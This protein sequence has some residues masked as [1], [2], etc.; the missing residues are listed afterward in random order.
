MRRTTTIPTVSRRR[1][2]APAVA[3]ALLAA[4][5]AAPSFAGRVQAQT[6]PAAKPQSYTD[7][8]RA[9]QKAR[10]E[11]LKADNGWLTVAG[12]FWL[13]EGD[14]TFG[15]APGNTIVLP[16]HSAADLAGV[17]TH[18]GGTTTVRANPGVVLRIGA[19]TVTSRALRS[20]AEGA[21]DVVEMGRLRFFVIHRG[22]RDAIRMRDLES[23]GRT[24][25]N[26]IRT[27]GIDPK[28]RI[29]ARFEP[30]DPPHR[31]PIA[32]IIGTVDSMVC[33][34][35]LVFMAGGREVRL[36]PVLEEPDATELFLIFSDLTSGDETY[37]AGR[38]LYA[39]LPQ[40]GK[41]IVDFNKAYNPPC[42]FTEFATCPLPPPQN[43]LPVAIRAGEKKYGNHR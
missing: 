17:F 15:C 27:Y 12:L 4:L 37:G 26:G 29:E 42:A 19:E 13:Q 18:S 10:V 9:W 11:R 28:W 43:A 3:A 5:V 21:P 16:A 32:S 25:F 23:W 14:N 24:H 6:P 31:I 2:P 40:G 33:P 34:G 8:I 30:Y 1:A 22:G 41:T 35:A 38:F 36:D 39:S 7:E 20:D